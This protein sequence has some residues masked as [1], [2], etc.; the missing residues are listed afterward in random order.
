MKGVFFKQRAIE[1]MLFNVILRSIYNLFS[2]ILG[3]PL[4]LD[5]TMVL[6]APGFLIKVTKSSILMFIQYQ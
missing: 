1:Q 4:N 5:A 3:C 2:I 6:K